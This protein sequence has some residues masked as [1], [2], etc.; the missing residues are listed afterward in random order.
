LVDKTDPSTLTFSKQVS[1][2]AVRCTTC[3]GPTYV[4]PYQANIALHRYPLV[5]TLY[6]ILKE[7]YSG[8]GN[9]FANFLEYERG[10]LIFQKAYLWPVRMNFQV[11]DVQIS[12]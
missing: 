10:Q 4:K 7:D 5:Q 12:Q 6:Y 8:I 11:R 3:G 2:A 1:V 9:N